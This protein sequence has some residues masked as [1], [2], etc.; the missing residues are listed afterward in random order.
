MSYESVESALATIL[1]AIAAFNDDQVT[2]ADWRVL[3]GG[4]PHGVVL[5]YGGF[6]SSPEALAGVAVHTWTVQ[7]HLYARYTDETE[8][9]G[10]HNVLRE[11]RQDI[12]DQILKN[13]TLGDEVG[14][15]LAYPTSGDWA[16][17][18]EV[19]I[20][21]VVFFHEVVNVEIEERQQVVAVE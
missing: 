21:S 5:E 2:R 4:A 10:V 18:Q 14:I 17:P 20:G 16:D 12:I 11:R 9:T 13:P 15:L 8:G 6:T 1:K 3:A 7:V 19:E